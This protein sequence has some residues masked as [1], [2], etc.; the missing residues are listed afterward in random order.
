MSVSR[1]VV[2]PRADW[3]LD[4]QAYYYATEGSPELG[5]RFL[6]AAHDTFSLLATQPNMGWHSRLKHPGLES[7][8]LFRVKRFEKIIILYLPLLDGETERFSW[9]PSSSK[10]PTTVRLG[11]R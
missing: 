10:G 7:L 3:D 8:R 1:Y 11:N 4:D 9:A 6:L 5:H 2:R